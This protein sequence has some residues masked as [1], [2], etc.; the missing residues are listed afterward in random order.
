M[1]LAYDLNEHTMI[2]YY[3]S[4]SININIYHIYIYSQKSQ[5]HSRYSR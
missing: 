3:L 4:L 5:L 2:D 1:Y